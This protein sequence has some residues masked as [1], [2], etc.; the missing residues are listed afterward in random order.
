[1]IPQKISMETEAGI[2]LTVL[3]PPAQQV[4]QAQQ[5][6]AALPVIR[7]QQELQVQQGQQGQVVLP[8]I[9]ARQV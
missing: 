7:G 4:Q 1:M 6:Q 9:Q 2:R 3:V 8:V 5:V